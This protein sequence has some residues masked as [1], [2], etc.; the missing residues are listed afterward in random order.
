LFSVIPL[1][2]YLFFFLKSLIPSFRYQPCFIKVLNAK[3]T[4]KKM[5]IE[6]AWYFVVSIAVDIFVSKG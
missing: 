6:L 1:I 3:E 2:F 4:E 5:G